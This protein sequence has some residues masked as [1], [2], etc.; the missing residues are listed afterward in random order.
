[1]IIN[2]YE[3]SSIPIITLKNLYFYR[4]KF[5]TRKYTPPRVHKFAR[6]F[7]LRECPNLLTTLAARDSFHELVEI[8]FIFISL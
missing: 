3:L 8:C 6:K 1:M 4:F 5:C 2:P 7:V